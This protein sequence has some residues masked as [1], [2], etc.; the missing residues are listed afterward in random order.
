MSRETYLEMC[1]QL[2]EEPVEEQIP[3]SLEDFPDLVQTCFIVYSLLPD[4][5]EYMGG[6]YCGKK[7]ELVF[8]TLELYN[9]VD[10]EEIKIAWSFLVKI[11]EVRKT[12]QSRKKAPAKK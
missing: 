11:D 9:I 8:Q 12:I 10:K 5:W 3:Y 2:G 1:D 6:N 7:Y 4:E